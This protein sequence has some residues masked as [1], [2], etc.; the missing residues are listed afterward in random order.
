MIALIAILISLLVSSSA[1]GVGKA[2]EISPNPNAEITTHPTWPRLDLSAFEVRSVSGIG[3]LTS[4]ENQAPV[5]IQ[6]EPIKD[7]EEID[8]SP[9]ES[10]EN[11]VAKEIEDM[12]NDYYSPEVI[13]DH[14]IFQGVNKNSRKDVELLPGP[15]EK[16]RT[17][18]TSRKRGYCPD[19]DDEVENISV[20]EEKNL[21][22]RRDVDE[23]QME[24]I[25]ATKNVR[26][27][28]LSASES[29][30]KQPLAVEFRHRTDLDESTS[31]VNEEEVSRSSARGHQAPHVDFVTANRRN[32]EG[33]ESRDLPLPR[34][35]PM[36]RDLPMSR[37]YDETPYRN[38]LR[39]RDPDS[40]Y[41]RGYYYPDHF[42]TE[43]DYYVRG[44]NEP[45][46]FSMDRYRIEDYDMYRNRP[47]PKPKRIIYYATLPE[48][49]RKPVDLRTY[50]RPYDSVSRASIPVGMI[51]RDRYHKRMPSIMDRDDTS[52]Q[53]RNYQGY[54][55]YDP[56]VKRSSYLDHP[57][58][59]FNERLEED[60]YRD[61]DLD[62]ASYK[63]AP[64]TRERED[65][66]KPVP[67]VEARV[68]QDK[69][70]WPVQIGTE[71]NVKDNQR[72]SGRKVFGQYPNYDRFRP[73]ARLERKDNGNDPSGETRH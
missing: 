21:R 14:P 47:T 69:A 53:Y 46:A 56:Y 19:N 48:I 2:W 27:P 35:A 30:S 6:E 22:V 9:E 64:E 25:A 70:P 3:R 12:E 15:W 5:N 13:Y 10:G 67:G 51:T 49:V 68:E 66:K 60:R 55:S 4:R 44:V 31:S 29:W 58:A 52:Y 72:V 1:D 63:E 26:E 57:Y 18:R 71:I 33:R 39:E 62:H 17:Q 8:T 45:A 32:F 41:S 36:A 16:S 65:P 20:G 37:S 7:R 54:N 43:R 38:S 73:S 11:R 24:K 42:R 61:Q 23:K 59:P 40:P 50:A 28:R 34:D